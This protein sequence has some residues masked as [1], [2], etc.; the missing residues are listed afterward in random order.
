MVTWN[1]TSPDGSKSVKANQT[2]MAQNTTYTET[3]LN[4]DHFWNIGANQDGRHNAIN[5]PKQAS[6]PATS[7]GMDG[8]V[9]IKEVSATNAR[10]EGFYRNVNGIYQFIPSFQEG[11][12]DFTSSTVQNIAVIPDN[13]YGQ[14]YLFVNDGTLSARGMCFGTFKAAGAK[15]QGYNSEGGNTAAVPIILQN[16]VDGGLTLKVQEV[17]D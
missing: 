13:S 7:T 8:T 9:F 10:I 2:P 1:S 5:M 17:M 12:A 16:N 6:D 11:T 4:G 3:V 14:I 15:V